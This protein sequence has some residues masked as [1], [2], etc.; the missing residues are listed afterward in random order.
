MDTWREVR[1]KARRCHAQAA[2][3]A[4]DGTAAAL[5]AAALAIADLEVDLFDP[6]TI[7]GPEVVGALDRGP[8]FVRLATTLDD[9]Q[10]TIVSAHEIGHFHLHDEQQ[11]LVRSTE[12]AFGG[13]PFETGG[14]KVVAY[15]PRERREIQAD[16]F[17]QEFLLPAD[18]LRQR[19]VAD[20]STPSQI[21]ADVGLPVAFVTMQAIRAML[22][23]PLPEQ[24]AD[25]EPSPAIPLDA[26]QRVAA[27][28]GDTPLIVDAGPG[29]GKTSTLVGRVE[30]LLAQGVQPWEILAL[31]FSNRAAAEMRERIER[32]DGA[33]A[34]QIWIGTFHA[35]GLEILHLYG[36]ECG[37]PDKLDILDE[38]GALGVLEGL[39]PGLT[40]HHFQNLWDP[41]LELRPILRAISRAKDEMITPE[42]YLAA[43]Q[44]ALAAADKPEAIE[45]AEKAVE[46]GG[47]YTVYQSAL[48]ASGKVDFGD[49]VGTAARLL[50]D[51][52]A[53][54]A[55]VQARHR[56]VLLD[57]YQDVN[58]ASTALLDQI[59]V[60]GQRVWTVA[61]PRQS[62][63]RFRGAAPS[64]ATGFTTRYSGAQSRPL[65]TNYR[66][67][68]AVVKL[69]ECY[70]SGIAAAPK[71]AVSWHP[72]RGA[73]G[74]VD[75]IQA[76]DLRSE[77][78]AVRDQIERLADKGIAYD[79][80]AIL[81]RTHLCLARFGRLLQEFDV[82]ILYLGDLFERPEI[83]DLLSLVSLGADADATGLLRVAQFPEYGG[84]REDALVIIRE[85]AATGENVL[86][87]C[88]G[89]AAIDGI[90]GRGGAGLQ[91]LAEHLADVGWTTTVW[92]V[93][94]RYLFESSGYL[95]RFVEDPSVRA[96]Q[97]LIAIYQL[98]KFAR[99]HADATRG[100][101][102][103]RPF[104][105]AI[106]RLERL[107]DDRAFRVVPPEADGIPAVRMM[108]VHAAKGLEF[109]AVHLPQVAT[110][111]V[112]S[113]RHPIRCP[114]PVGLEHLEVQQADHKAEEECLFFVA[115]SRARDVLSISSAKRYTAKLGCSPSEYLKD[116]T[117]VLPKPRLAPTIAPAISVTP[118]VP[119]SLSGATY[120]E[121]HLLIYVKCPARYRYEV[122]DELGDRSAGSAYLA[123][124]GCVRST[125]AWISAQRSEGARVDLADAREYLAEIWDERGPCGHGFEP[126][127]RAAAEGM[128]ANAVTALADAG[129]VIDRHWSVVVGGRTI[130]LRPD[131]VVEMPDGTVLA[132]VFKTGRK[133]KSERTKAVWELLGEAV[134]QTHPGRPFELQAVY[135]AIPEAVPIDPD[136]GGKGIAE[137]GTA[138][139]GIEAGRFEPTPSTDCPTCRFYFVCTAEDSF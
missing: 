66:S 98:L 36:K 96:Q 19:L 48:E 14:E 50:K 136:Q 42:M 121:R 8:G 33:A 55:A 132:Q 102:G 81:A 93:L 53:V 27:E 21:A 11:S 38:A 131:R 51:H 74:F 119:V 89:A 3:R 25:E 47:V 73:I 17:A 88:A 115:L 45:R 20:G 80:Q 72:K 138:L 34:Q 97:C 5:V 120:D 95:Q 62:I 116:L 134:R 52:D 112:P 111:Y 40:L 12:A 6:G 18:Q 31:T 77:A 70:G 1:V 75:H 122:L 94:V 2:A 78:S 71:P 128:V 28:W 29:T 118:A 23:P 68:S 100:R 125:I 129:Q 101:G 39:L 139:E 65:T 56:Y 87:I 37:L 16:I 99:E 107:D 49:L 92:Q 61:D 10:K 9:G 57:E 135:P 82:P 76:E 15:S 109:R 126:V 103:R 44:A 130:H 13:Q 4:S 79:Q 43:A 64:N 117:A 85:A 105:D 7:H 91:R 106:R 24:S 54:R 46:V 63:Y 35:F 108:T 123:F 22:L 32:I 69:F 137:Y 113:K 124:H 60:G 127:Y 104:L 90:T 58:S 41:A 59:A 26:D 83:R 84:T 30:Y 133:S 114:A 86:A 110:R 67:G